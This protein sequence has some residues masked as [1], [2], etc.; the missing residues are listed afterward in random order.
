[1]NCLIDICKT[2]SLVI[3][4][5]RSPISL[6][7]SEIITTQRVRKPIFSATLPCRFIDG[8]RLIGVVKDFGYNKIS[9]YPSLGGFGN[10]F[11]YQGYIFKKENHEMP[12]V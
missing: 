5:D 10:K 11:S 3:I 1:V 8:E 9:Q 4:I 2:D 6:D 12:T 7:P